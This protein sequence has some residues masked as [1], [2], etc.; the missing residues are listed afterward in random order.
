MLLASS[1]AAKLWAAALVP[2]AVI[3]IWRRDGRRAALEWLGV[4]VLVAAAWFG[5]FVVASPSGVGHMFHEQLA[6]P[7]Q[8]ESLGSS[9]LIALHHIG[10]TSLHVV[11]TFGS[12]NL[13]GTGVG[14]VTLLTGALE[15]ASLA[16]IYWL[17]ARGEPSVDRLLLSCA[18]VTTT[19]LAFGKVFSPQFLIWLVPLVPLVRG[20]C[21]PG[22]SSLSRS[23]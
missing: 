6:R 2:L 13:T 23:C 14:A 11:S 20:G 18:A 8:I 21:P 7:L 22:R 9:L 10:G 1:F 19:L 15:L 4:V 3:W 17:F 16:G 12:Q 5:P